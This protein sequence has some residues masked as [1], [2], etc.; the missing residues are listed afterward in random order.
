MQGIVERQDDDSGALA[1]PADRPRRAAPRSPPPISTSR[2]PRRARPTSRTRAAIAVQA[3]EVPRDHPLADRRRGAAGA[4]GA[5]DP[6]HHGRHVALQAPR[7]AAARTSRPCPTRRGQAAVEMPFA[8]LPPHDRARSCSRCRP[9]SRA[10]SSTARSAR[11]SRTARSRW[12]RPTA[13]AW[14]WSKR[15]TTERQ[16]E[17]RRPG[18]A[19]GAPGAAA[20]RGRASRSTSAAASTTCRSASAGAS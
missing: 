18:A 16:G 3:Q 15:R 8:A 19:Q 9:R 4:G 1:P 2:S 6:H 10:S 14:R 17:G 11:S 12:W 7:P 5:R 13:T 20:P